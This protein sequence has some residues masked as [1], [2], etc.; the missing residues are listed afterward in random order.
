[1]TNFLKNIGPAT[2][3]QSILDDLVFSR[4]PQISEYVSPNHCDKV[5]DRIGD[6][7]LDALLV[8][9]PNCRAGIEVIGFNG[10]ILIAGEAWSKSVGISEI[11]EIA[12]REAA[13]VIAEVGDS[14]MEICSQIRNQDSTIQIASR[15][16]AGDQAVCVGFASA[17]SSD[18]MPREHSL[19]RILT[20][21]LLHQASGSTRIGTDGKVVVEVS[22]FRSEAWIRWQILAAE[23]SA[24]A[25]LTDTAHECGIETVHVDEDVEFRTNRFQA[26]TGVLGRKLVSDHY[27]SR[28]PIGGGA[29]SGK[30]ASKPDRTGNYAARHVA[31]ETV[32]SCGGRALVF[33]AYTIGHDAPVLGG[34]IC[35][36][37]EHNVRQL[38]LNLSELSIS[39]LTERFDLR[40]RE[41]GSFY[42]LATQGHFGRDLPW[43]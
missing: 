6:R 37:S 14:E 23:K 43:D 21:R 19:A 36:D 8:V 29:I 11:N 18:L 2:E 1:M 42:D 20:L 17:E 25:L 26:D 27:G 10:R 35:S 16:G 41:F 33:L 9:D 5:C 12:T 4:T 15:Q 28:V 31:C 32:R 34:G 13:W 7:I 24:Y 39:S 3:S 30:D 22:G 38:T 40:N